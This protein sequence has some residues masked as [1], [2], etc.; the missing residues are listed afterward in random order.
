[1]EIPYNGLDDDCNE[2]SLDDDL[3]QDGFLLEDDCDDTN[4]EINPDANEIPNNGIDEDCDGEDL[5]T[6]VFE[7]ANARMNIF[8]NP[9]SEDIN[10]KVS[11]TFNYRVEIFELNGKLIHSSKNTHRLKMNSL[12][13]GTYL[14]KVTDLNSEHY[15]LEK[16]VKI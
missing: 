6:S 5:S 15:I 3:D 8:P 16:L 4:D 9:V 12:Y 1:M 2:M 13:R 11:D 10:I 7:L 14:L